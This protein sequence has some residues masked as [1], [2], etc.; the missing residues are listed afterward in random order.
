VTVV[1]QTGD[2]RIKRIYEAVG[3]LYDL[4]AGKGVGRVTAVV[5]AAER[6]RAIVTETATLLGGGAVAAQL[7][8]AATPS[9]EARS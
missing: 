8:G 6:L 9:A 1:K 4:Y 2:I 7:A 3:Q 5:G